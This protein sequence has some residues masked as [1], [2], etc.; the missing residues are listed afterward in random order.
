[1]NLE[2]YQDGEDIDSQ[3][4]R[5]ERRGMLL[6]IGAVILMATIVVGAALLICGCSNSP[7]SGNTYKLTINVLT[8]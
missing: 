2:P 7:V 4:D 5:E 6:G 3:L 8:P 1:M